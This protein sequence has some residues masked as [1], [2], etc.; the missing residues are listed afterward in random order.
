MLDVASGA[1][2]VASDNATVTGL[3]QPFVDVGNL[4]VF[5]VFP[6]IFPIAVGAVLIGWFVLRYTVFGRFIDAIGTNEEEAARL[7]GHDR[8]SRGSPPSP[9]AG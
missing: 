9:S 5:G 4:I 2:R 1:A 6:A 3:P 8:G 7:S